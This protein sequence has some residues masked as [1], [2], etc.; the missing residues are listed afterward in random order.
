[1]SGKPVSWWKENSY[2]ALGKLVCFLLVPDIKQ[3]FVK[4]V[5]ATPHKNL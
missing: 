3:D 2:L 5:P 4:E 1:M